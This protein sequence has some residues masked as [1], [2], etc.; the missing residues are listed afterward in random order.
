MAKEKKKFKKITKYK[1]LSKDDCFIFPFGLL[2]WTFILSSLG[3]VWYKTLIN[4]ILAG[5]IGVPTYIFIFNREVY[6]EEI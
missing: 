3:Y 1:P 5:I 4:I 6:Y 2:V